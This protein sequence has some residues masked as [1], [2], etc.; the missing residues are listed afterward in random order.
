MRRAI[1]AVADTA[2]SPAAAPLL[3]VPS[4]TGIDARLVLAGPGARTI[5]FIFDWM[6]RGCLA[7]AW[8]L[9]VTWAI[10]GSFGTDVPRD[11]DTLWI[12][13]GAVPASTIYFLY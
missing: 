13:T 7:L 1:P 10:T 5:A 9:L 3:T 4:A 12:L 6:I 8:L 2:F 11:S